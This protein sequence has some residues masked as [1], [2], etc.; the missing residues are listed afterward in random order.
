MRLL[1]KKKRLMPREAEML[2]PADAGSSAVEELARYLQVR[3]VLTPTQLDEMVDAIAAGEPGAGPRA[4]TEVI[5]LL[6]E[7]GE[8]TDGELEA[9]VSPEGVRRITYVPELVR[10]QLRE[11]LRK[12]LLDQMK[13]EGWATPNALPDWARRLRLSGDVRT[14]Y[15]RDLFGKGNANHGEFPDFNAI[16]NN[17]PFDVNFVD[18]ANERY[19]NVD[20]DRTRTRLRARLGVDA[21]VGEGFSSGMRLATG[22]S[23]SPVSTNQ[24]LGTGFSKLAVWVD[25]AFIRY[26]ALGGGRL[27]GEAGRFDDPFLHTDLIWD[28]DLNF[29]GLDV[30]GSWPVGSK[31][32]PFWVAGVFPVFTTAL[33]FP[34]EQSAKF[35][36]LD[37]WLY[38]IQLGSSF[39]VSDR[40]TAKFG[41]AYYGFDGIEGRRSSP[42][43]T[44]L[45]DISCDTDHTRPP[46]AQRG[47][48]YMALR[49]PSEA[50]LAAEAAGL[51]SRY[52]FFGLASRFQEIVVTGRGDLAMG[53]ALKWTFE[54]EYANNVAFSRSR[55]EPIAL[56]NRGPVTCNGSVCLDQFVGGNQAFQLKVTVGSP[57]Q[58]NRWDWYAGLSYRYIESDAVVDAF[59]DSDFGLGG[60]NIVGYSLAASLAVAKGVWAGARVY[61]ADQLVGPR[62]EV[63]VVQVDLTARF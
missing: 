42:C 2:V 34:P 17:K 62:Y 22:D 12:E 47:N 54:A 49:T 19:L 8:L 13:R 30:R 11:Q 45:K 41:V 50:A 44:N 10:V 26:D 20:Q 23:A 53:A 4:V 37:K 25:R 48:T 28:E 16:N 18:F 3:G 61:F 6:F 57:T 14:R 36:S 7:K 40:F 21:D 43:D 46:F 24:T 15:E 29:D 38:A 27:V 32:R 9:L 55:M 1:V 39:Q 52:Q 60:T 33:A 35:A 5:R 59:N 56:N 51:A 63:D 58:T 31:A